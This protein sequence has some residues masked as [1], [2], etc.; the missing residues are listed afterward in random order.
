MVV[1]FKSETTDR[2]EAPSNGVNVS[3]TLNSLFDQ[4]MTAEEAIDKL[5][6]WSAADRDPNT[7]TFNIPTTGEPTAEPTSTSDK[8]R[9]S[10]R[11]SPSAD[12]KYNPYGPNSVRVS[13]RPI[14]LFSANDPGPAPPMGLPPLPSMVPVSMGSTGAY[15]VVPIAQL[16]SDLS[17]VYLQRP[18][19]TQLN[20]GR[21]NMYSTTNP[22]GP[23]PYPI[24]QSHGMPTMPSTN[25]AASLPVPSQSHST[26]YPHRHNLFSPEPECREAAARYL[27]DKLSATG[28][29][30]ALGASKDTIQRLS[31]QSREASEEVEKQRARASK[32]KVEAEDLSSKRY[33]LEERNQ[34]MKEEIIRLRSRPG[35]D[36]SDEDSL[37]DD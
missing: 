26:Q 9:N 3:E 28:N 4:G 27:R 35:G 8:P 36:D 20:I 13:Q 1:T 25:P 31:A 11:P 5:H 30:K 33:A 17:Q 29:S 7:F 6:P 18:G 34:S 23:P 16:N 10:S 12:I 19:A 37:V 22:T 15:T 32:W 21:P 24:M 2:T 14:S